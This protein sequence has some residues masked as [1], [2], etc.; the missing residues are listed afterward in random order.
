M[1]Y[2]FEVVEVYPAEKLHLVAKGLPI[3]LQQA[4]KE[5]QKEVNNKWQS[6]TTLA[7]WNNIIRKKVH[8]EK[9]HFRT[10]MKLTTVAIHTFG[11][12]EKR[13][14]GGRIALI[15]PKVLRKELDR[16]DLTAEDFLTDYPD[17]DRAMFSNVYQM[18]IVPKVP[19]L[20]KLTSWIDDYDNAR[21]DFPEDPGVRWDVEEWRRTA[22]VKPK[23]SW[24]EKKD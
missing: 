14:T 22:N 17:E 8:L 24:E 2:E 11:K 3:P 12:Y 9:V 23:D 18:R 10:L 4:T 21:F 6:S 19:L 16:R 7:S 1:I 5:Y 20:T 13:P 15:N